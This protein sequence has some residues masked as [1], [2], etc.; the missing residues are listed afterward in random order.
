MTNRFPLVLDTTDDNKI[1][2]LPSGDNLDLQNSGIVNALTIQVNS[3]DTGT[4]TVNGTNFSSVAFSG[5]YDDLSDTPSQFDKD[6]NSLTNKPSIPS[7]FGDLANV[8]AHTPEDGQIVI[9]KT[10]ENRFTFADRLSQIDLSN[11]ELNDLGDVAFA[12]PVTDKFI[13][14][15]AGGWRESN[16]DWSDVINKPTNVSYFT[17][18]ADYIT[19]T[20]L[21]DIVAN[22]V[23]F[24]DFKN[25]IANDL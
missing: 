5:S 18:D 7:V 2:E 14:Y 12:G 15:Y 3:L 17:N 11:Y 6:Y 1:K 16:I 9:W 24:D 13:K 23:D 19:K 8:A 25:K 10:D 21:K 20:E 22:S 4:L